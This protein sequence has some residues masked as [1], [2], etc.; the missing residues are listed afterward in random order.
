MNNGCDLNCG[1]M[2]L[3]LFQAYKDGLVDEAAIDQAVVRLYATRMK[4]GLFEPQTPWAQLGIADVDTEGNAT[5]NESAAEK[6]LVLLKNN[7]VLPLKDVSSIA[8]IGPN[9][10]SVAALEGNYCGTSSEYITPLRGIR[11]KANG[12]RIYYA[13]G[14]HLWKDKVEPLA[15]P[16]DRFAEAEAAAKAAD[17]SI[18]CVGLDASLEGE[19]GDASNS[20]TIGDKPDLKLP[21]LQEEL[22]ERVAAVGKP[23]VVVCLSGSA[24]DLSYAHEHAAAVVQ[25]WYPG[26]QGGRAVAA[27]LFGGFSPSGR[28]PL[29]FYRSLESVPE[30][31]DYSMEGRTYRYI[32]EEPLYP[33]G[34]GL[35][36]TSFAFGGVEAPKEYCGEGTAKIKAVVSNEGAMAGRDVVQLYIKRYDVEDRFLPAPIW[37]LKAIQTVELAPSES[38][39]VEFELGA[40]SFSLFDR[41]GNQ[42]MAPGKAEVYIGGSQPDQRSVE[43]TGKAPLKA[44]V[45]IT[46]AVSIRKAKR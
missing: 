11:E 5:A 3:H 9:A 24:M 31:T 42:E 46:G 1:A 17:V 39:T 26:A 22:L 44:S 10:D 2:Y 20:R 32:K 45:E 23:V 37:S 41:D 15:L 18:V 43:L 16:G 13:P 40:E 12:A 21:G 36:Y 30:F 14:C 35:S 7:G 19:E 6:T 8:V 38:K 33:F 27:L 4:L 28:L 34:Y 25:A 29:T